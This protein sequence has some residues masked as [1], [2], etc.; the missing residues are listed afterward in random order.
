M[1]LN[2]GRE[3]TALSRITVKQLCARYAEVFG[4]QT[5]GRNKAWLVK[6]ITRAGGGSARSG[7]PPHLGLLPPLALG[8][9][10]APVAPRITE[11]RGA[12]G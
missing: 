8:R 9:V 6:R 3:V 7:F 1:S 12:E 11:P 4:E 10:S 2:V 5:G